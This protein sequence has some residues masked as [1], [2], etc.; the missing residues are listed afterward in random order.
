MVILL[1]MKSLLEPRTWKGVV[2]VK[3][4]GEW[5]GWVSEMVKL[6]GGKRRLLGVEENGLY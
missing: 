2:E 3:V 6:E 5:V 4:V 1:C